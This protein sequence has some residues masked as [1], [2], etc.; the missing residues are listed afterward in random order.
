MADNTPGYKV[1][2]ATCGDGYFAMRERYDGAWQALRDEK[3]LPIRFD[4]QKA[5]GLACMVDAA[6]NA[7]TVDIKTVCQRVTQVRDRMKEQ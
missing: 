7:G 5:A 2:P 1:Q 6:R 3:R 4:T